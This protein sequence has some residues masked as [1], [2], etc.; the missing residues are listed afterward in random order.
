M[1]FLKAKPSLCL[2][3]HCFNLTAI[4]VYLNAIIKLGF[5]SRKCSYTMSVDFFIATVKDG[6]KIQY[7]DQNQSKA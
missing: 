4:Y 7:F 3:S 1:Y 5:S 6:T 2:I